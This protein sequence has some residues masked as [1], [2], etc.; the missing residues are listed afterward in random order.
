MSIL[1]EVINRLTAITIKL[2]TA[3]FAKIER[4][5]NSQIHKE[6]QGGYK[7]I[8]KKNSTRRLTLPNIKTYYKPTVIKI[9]GI[10]MALI[11]S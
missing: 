7:I 10:C 5:I 8:L 11:Y 1:H 3:F 2:P 9:I 6:L 4:P